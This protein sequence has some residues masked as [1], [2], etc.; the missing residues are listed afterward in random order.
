[1]SATELLSNLA[2]NSLNVFSIKRMV[3]IDDDSS[4]TE[5]NYLTIEGTPDAYRWLAA[6]LTQMAN[7]TDK[8]AN[9]CAVVVS[10]RDLKQINMTQWSSISLECSRELET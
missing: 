3:R 1:M 4:E 2:P 5:Q 10:P 8:H 6:Q 7:S 9:G